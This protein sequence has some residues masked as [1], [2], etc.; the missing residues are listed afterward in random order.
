MKKS[1]TS[2]LMTFIAVACLAH[3]VEV[4][5]IFYNLVENT[6][7]GLEVP[8]EKKGTGKEEKNYFKLING[9][10]CCKYS[11][12]QHYFNLCYVNVRFYLDLLRLLRL[13]NDIEIIKTECLDE[14]L[15]EFLGTNT[16]FM[17]NPMNILNL[18]YK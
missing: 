5:G 11:S 8:Y 9:F 10:I 15:S 2:I 6:K 16:K 14:K 1:I 13:Y 7:N 4:N 17:L 18:T 12:K 3:D